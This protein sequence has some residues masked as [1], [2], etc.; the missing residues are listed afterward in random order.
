[1]NNSISISGADLISLTGHTLAE[2]ARIMSEYT[3]PLATSQT[4]PNASQHIQN[5]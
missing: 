4:K 1:M 3:S 2:G 5:F